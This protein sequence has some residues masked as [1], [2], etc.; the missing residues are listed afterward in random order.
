MSKP[1][2]ALGRSPGAC[3]VYYYLLWCTTAAET[4]VR[5][6]GKVVLITGASE[7]IGA[8]CA[9]V[10]RKRGARLSLT[11]RSATKLQSVGGGDALM[12]AG[13]ITDPAVRNEVVHRTLE[14]FGSI[15]VL[16]NSAGVG[17]YAP[18]WCAPMK[19]LRQMFDRN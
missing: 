8:A 10:L 16:I 1:H 2:Y 4:Q 12:V 17:L 6:E 9:Q 5:I 15:D 14:R 11:A 19:D 13:D 18:A 7:G 3:H